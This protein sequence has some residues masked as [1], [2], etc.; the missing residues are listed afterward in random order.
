MKIKWLVI[1]LSVIIS[2]T[3]NAQGIEFF[4]GT[5]KEALEKA[6]QENKLLFVDAFAKWC[7]PCKS[8]AKNVFTK[9][10]VGK[11]FNENFI[12]LKLDME[13]MDGITFG[14]IYPVKAYPTLFFVDGD[15]KLVKRMVGGQTVDGLLALGADALKNIDR[16]DKYEKQY[17]EG[18]RSYQ[19]LYDYV[20]ALNAAGKPSLKISNDY[21]NS[22]PN[23]TED[24]RLTFLL[25]AATEADSKL[26]DQVLENKNK[27]ILLTSSELFETKTK[28]ACNKTVDKAIEFEM[29]SLMTETFDKAKKAFPSDADI[30]VA[31]A[32]M[33]YF[34]IFK[35]ED[36]FMDAYRVLAKKGGKDPKTLKKI[37][38]DILSTYASNKK[39]MNDAAEYAEK[40]YKMDMEFESLTLY[41]RVLVLNNDLEKAISM[42][43]KAKNI[44]AKL[45]QDTTNYD[46]MLRF[47]NSKK[48]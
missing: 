8:M 45:G 40:A 24:Q 48:A 4:H 22:N 39:M 41:C 28:A 6:R 47:L 12:N 10:E 5:W 25:E 18:D 37:T 19:L 21:L 31:E 26:F 15:G 34:K 16:S 13:E 32:K 30:F 44:A 33:K 14:H 27:I 35:N 23:I 38:N 17:L 3:I 1:V 29:E 42:V 11:F 36:K 7:G 43:E 46:G 2:P 9:E 20:S